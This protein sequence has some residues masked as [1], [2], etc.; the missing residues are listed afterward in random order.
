MTADDLSTQDLDSRNLDTQDLGTH[1]PSSRERTP[2]GR[3]G[4]AHGDAVQPGHAPVTH[5]YDGD[6]AVFHIGMTIRRPLRPDLWMPVAAA[7]PR[8]LAE[9]EERRRAAERGEVEDLGFLGAQ[10]LLGG[11]GPWV[12]QWWRSVDALYA[13][14]HD[15]EAE[16]LPAWRRFNRMARTHPGAVGI[17]HETYA[18]PAGAVESIYVGGARTGL[19]RAVGTVPVGRRGRTARERLGGALAPAS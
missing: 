6:L 12:V 11:G 17:W 8:M 5:A 19:G 7:M 15:P 16:H 18:V 3:P 13:Y 4:T 2:P 1:D 10:T 14:A 9:L